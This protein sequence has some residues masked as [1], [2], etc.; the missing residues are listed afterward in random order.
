MAQVQIQALS[1]VLNTQKLDL[2]TSNGIDVNFFLGYE[3]EYNYIVNH[4]KEY[5]TTPDIATFLAQFPTFE[6]LDVN[7]TDR[8]IIDTLWEEHTFN[9][10]VPILQEGAKLLESD[11]K[12]A[13]EFITSRI[14][15]LPKHTHNRAL[16][17]ISDAS[18]RYQ[19]FLDR[20]D[21]Q[22]SWYFTTGFQELDDL[23]HGL[24]RGEELAV[25]FARVNQGKSWI[26][27]KMCTHIW[28][29]G[30][31]VGYIS[32]EMSAD[33]IGYRFDTLHKH[34]SNSGLM[35][36]KDEINDGDYKD[37]IDELKSHKNKFIVA[38]PLDFDNKIT[39]TKLRNLVIENHLD[40]LAV[41]GIKYLSDE[42]GKRGD[43][44][45]TTLTNISE[46]LMSLSMELKIPI[47]VVVQANR[48][49]TKDGKPASLELE[50]IRDSDGI[51]HCASKVLSVRQIKE[52]DSSK[53]ELC[54][55][56]QR[57]GPVGGKLYYQWD[58]NNG[59]F[60]Y[61]PT[62]GDARPMEETREIARKNKDK[63]KSDATDVF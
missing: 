15:S 14:S 37:Y 1:K 49:A 42:R 48:E 10:T 18:S 41:D 30:F 28:E 22:D 46:D 47:L 19:Q 17:I 20:R 32:P 53:L 2:I 38:T 54:I 13:V 35:W 6:V 36:G 8:Y 51:S 27:S 61:L 60:T 56:K 52:D 16:D 63:F 40:C 59:I 29:I 33:S 44:T 11:S 21:N 4:Y 57:F 9:L 24:Q 34:Y 58:I 43:N 23:L 25:I 12:L 45:T 50:T 3:E 39:I 55:K 7:E 62:D 31:N 26:L 5:S